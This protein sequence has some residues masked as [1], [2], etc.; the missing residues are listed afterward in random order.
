MQQEF[1]ALQTGSKT[2]VEYERELNRLM[3]FAPD[4]FKNDKE[5]RMQ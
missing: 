4:A 2:A 5:A 1:Y 3:N